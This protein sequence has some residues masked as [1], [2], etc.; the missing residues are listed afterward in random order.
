MSLFEQAAKF[1]GFAAEKEGTRV[2]AETLRF[3][4]LSKLG[5]L[6]TNIYKGSE[7]VGFVATDIEDKIARVASATVF[8][9]NKGIG[10]QA[11]KAIAAHLFETTNIQELTSDIVHGTSKSAR[12]MW[13]KLLEEGVAEAFTFKRGEAIGEGFRISRESIAKAIPKKLQMQI[14]DKA[15]E[16]ML[17]AGA[18]HDNSTLLNRSMFSKAGSRR[19][20]SVL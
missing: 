10:R 14:A 5:T 4:H 15:A 3:E 9:P 7:V 12:G 1:A 16:D 6:T 20:S 19:T 2:A 17:E 13:G 11:Y 18:G 8:E